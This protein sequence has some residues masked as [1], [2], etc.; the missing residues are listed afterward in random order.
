MSSKQLRNPKLKPGDPNFYDMNGSS[1]YRM[2]AHPAGSEFD[3]Y[4]AQAQAGPYA[5]LHQ[6]ENRCLNF[7]SPCSLKKSE[8][9]VNTGKMIN[10]GA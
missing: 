3:A 7:S 4:R 8:E 2:K 10:I 5:S 6:P 1:G 9:W